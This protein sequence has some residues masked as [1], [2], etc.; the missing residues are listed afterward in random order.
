MSTSIIIQLIMKSSSIAN[1]RKS[2]ARNDCERMADAGKVIF[3]EE[4]F[5]LS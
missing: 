5:L 1:A 3:F 4:S 2:P